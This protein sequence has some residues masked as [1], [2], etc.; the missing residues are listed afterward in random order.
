MSLTLSEAI[1]FWI[2]Q[3]QPKEWE[4]HLRKCLREEQELSKI[5]NKK[6]RDTNE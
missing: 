4:K 2:Q 3:R 1:D 5:K 6:W